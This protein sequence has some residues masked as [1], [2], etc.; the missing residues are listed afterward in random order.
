MKIRDFFLF[1]WVI[2]APLDPHPDP[3]TQ[4][5]ADPDPDTDP[6]PKPC[7]TVRDRGD[8]YPF[9]FWTWCLPLKNIFPFLLLPAKLISDYFDIRRCGSNNTF[10]LIC[11]QNL[12]SV[13][14]DAARTKKSESSTIHAATFYRKL[15]CRP[16]M[17]V[18]F[19]TRKYIDAPNSLHR[20]TQCQS[21][22]P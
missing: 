3:A 6:D 12:R 22:R 21:N 11:A 9:Y 13:K 18:I 19:I 2:F 15:I 1:L 4:I 5:N 10:L 14:R 17:S 20:K 8:R 16:N 7:K